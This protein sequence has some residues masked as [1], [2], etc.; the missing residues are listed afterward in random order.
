MHS[1]LSRF[2][3]FSPSEWIIILK[4]F[5]VSFLDKSSMSR[6]PSDE[7]RHKAQ[8]RKTID[9]YG[10]RCLR[11][12]AFISKFEAVLEFQ[13]QYVSEERPSHIKRIIQ[14]VKGSSRPTSRIIH[15]EGLMKLYSW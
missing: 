7:Q 2:R 10:R 14:I 13:C 6:S 12:I 11:S 8:I 5:I 4:K 3:L 15:D 1:F 9:Q